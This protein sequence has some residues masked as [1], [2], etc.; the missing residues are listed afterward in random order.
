M[1][2]PF[3]KI[4]HTNT[5]PSDADCQRIRE[6]LVEPLKN[7]AELTA[8]IECLQSQINQLTEKRDRLNTFIDPHLALISPARR[9]PA[10][11]VAEIFVA[12][13]PSDRN[14]IIS[15]IEAPL[16]LC[17]VCRQWRNIALTTPRLWASLHIVAPGEKKCLQIRE[18]VDIWLS[19]S[20]VLP[21]SISLVH[22]A[23]VG[24]DFRVV[25]EV[26]LSY[27]SRWNRIRI[28]LP[29]YHHF[30]PLSILSPADVPILES[31]VIDGFGGTDPDWS[32]IAF[33][34]VTSLRSVTFRRALKYP[35]VPVPWDQ[36]RHLC[37]DQGSHWLLTAAE[38]LGLLRR[39]PNLETCTLPFKPCWGIPHPSQ[40]VVWNVCANYPWSMS[41]MERRISLITLIFLVWSHWNTRHG[42]SR[43]S[44][45]RLS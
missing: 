29:A 17:H 18:A 10:E 41:G 19:R 36:L 28:R 3:E 9:L 12:C 33:L 40:N 20:G 13:L 14:A 22:S 43:N 11:I 23:K 32:F 6:L 8:Q 7:A 42:T 26:L 45:S 5:V 4:L 27:A 39:C 15:G 31:A 30:R 35:Q 24:F 37:V 38:A 2:S 1:D 21:L 34:G 16:L 44:L 25:L